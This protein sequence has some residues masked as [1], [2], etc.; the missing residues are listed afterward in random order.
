MDSM[1][2]E[3]STQENIQVHY[4]RSNYNRSRQI[5]LKS[6]KLASSRQ[7]PTKC[8]TIRKVSGC[9]YQGH[10][11]AECWFLSKFEIA[12][13]LQIFVDDVDEA[14]DTKC[15]VQVDPVVSEIVSSNPSVSKV[16]CD[17]ITIFLRILKSSSLPCGDDTGATSSVISQSF[18]KKAADITPRSTFHSA[19]TIC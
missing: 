9:E 15:P 2:A 19:H 3:I 7:S 11:V 1:L 6:N 16:Q 5:Q 14:E 8:C 18:L 10:N 13:A 17:Y 4:A 12:K